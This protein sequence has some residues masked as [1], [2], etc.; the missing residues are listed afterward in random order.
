MSDSAEQRPA[1][2]VISN[3]HTPYRLA[4]HRRLAR[5]LRE[6]EVW[7][8]Y[9]HELSNAPWRFDAAPETNPVVFGAGQSADT[10][11]H[12]RHVGREFAKGGRI[13]RWLKERRVQAVVLL[14]YNDAGRLRI[15]G[16]CRR[17]G[18]PAL[19]FADNNIKGDLARGIKARVKRLVVTRVLRACAAGLACGSLGR[20][21]FR[22]YGMPDERIFYMP[23]EPD[24]ELLRRISAGEIEAAR[25]RFGL[26]AG[27]R[28]FVF[29]GRLVGVKRA[30]LV[31]EAFAAVAA[32][33]PE[34]DLLVVG[35]G[36]LRDQLERRVPAALRSRVTWTGFLDDQAVVGALYRASDVLVLPSDYEPWA[37]VVNE[38]VAAGLAVIA[39]DVVGAAAELVRDGVNGAIFP[40]GDG[41]A[42][43]EAMRRVTAP[44]AI[45]RLKAGSA[46]VLEDWRR[47][48]DPVNGLREAL[49]YVG[50]LPRNA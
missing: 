25:A 46:A 26:A 7:N 42:L 3:A 47:R 1:V 14:G 15:L 43:V 32:E 38:A 4:F 40:A 34:W 28:R 17:H 18:V 12:A 35:D 8:L 27:R 16:W 11:A 44:E 39:S 5:E 22:K 6:A 21:Y 20:A 50:V 2:A 30:D 37:L 49:R 23:Y 13:I 10:Q 36:P 33:R 9:T 41:V 45:D 19:L 31:I 48:A 29:S 24:Y